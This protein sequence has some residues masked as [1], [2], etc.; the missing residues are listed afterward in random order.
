MPTAARPTPSAPRPGDGQDGF[1]FRSGRLCLDFT[2]TLAGRKKAA[3]RDRLAAPGDLGRWLAAAGLAARAPR[4]TE[5][6]LAA[7]RALR[8]ALYRLARAALD[9][10]AYPARDLALLNHWAAQPPPVPQLG[11]RGLRWQGA[12][13][14]ALL[15]AVAREGV[16]LLGGPA[17]ARLRA[18]EGE[19]C[20]LL[21]VDTSRA[22]RRRWCSMTACGNR[23]KVGAF[24][25]RLREG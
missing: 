22:G 5:E 13:V 12:G 14:P 18:C 21:F 25:L 9:G 16:E 6:D 10:R 20:A 2:A 4:A 24:R 3:P 15:A 1:V 11:E 19:G 23:E 7:A 17:A 8:E